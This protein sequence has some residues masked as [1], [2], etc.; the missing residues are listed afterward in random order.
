MLIERKLHNVDLSKL[1]LSNRAYSFKTKV[2]KVDCLSFSKYYIV[3]VF[4]G[5]IEYSREHSEN[6]EEGFYI[7]GP[8]RKPSVD[9][10]LTF[11]AWLKNVIS[12]ERFTDIIESVHDYHPE[13]KLKEIYNDDNN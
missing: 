2:D 5:Y 8:H 11:I 3:G 9:E 12:E 1:T 4:S 6:F 10:I 7:F 13:L